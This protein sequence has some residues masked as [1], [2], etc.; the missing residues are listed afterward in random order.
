MA[1]TEG[2]DV[3]PFAE[4][5]SSAPPMKH[6]LSPLR[7][8]M[9]TT[10]LLFIGEMMDMALLY[11]LPPLPLPLEVS[12]D[13]LLLTTLAFP[14][15]YVLLFRPLTM[16]ITRRKLAEETL[17]KVQVEAERLAATEEVIAAVAHGIRNP[18]GNI[19]LVTQEML[20]VLDPPHVLR[21]PLGEII[22]QVDL[23]EARLRSF[24]SMTRPFDLSLTFT[25]VADLVGS[26]IQG[27]RQRLANQGVKV[28][29]DLDA[30][31]TVLYCDAVKI[32]EALQE[33]LVNSVQAQADT[34]TIVGRQVM[35]NVQKQWIRL[36]IEDNGTGLSPD[37]VDK[38]LHP[39]FTTK[40]LGTGLGLAVAKRI[41]E[42]HDGKLFLE[43]S[44]TRGTR[45]TVW[46]PSRLINGKD[47]YCGGY[48]S[49]CRG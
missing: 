13:A 48:G 36:T 39:F 21:E 25:Q 7:L 18:L 17:K 44:H 4:S 47:K 5:P 33:L 34:I 28:S 22:G 35:D 32:E 38:A 46:L 14:T 24:L 20:E 27:I 40:P 30:G 41:I 29:V 6:Y 10:V 1:S 26:A 49:R 12:F 2:P 43:A 3:R 8:L 42:E 16:Q 37:A 45:A 15:L 9:V 11:F 31:R 23:L 19:R